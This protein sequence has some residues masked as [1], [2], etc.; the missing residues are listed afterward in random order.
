MGNYMLRYTGV[1]YSWDER[2]QDIPLGGG[3]DCEY[4]TD[5]SKQRF[6]LTQICSNG[7]ETKDGFMRA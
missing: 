6:G 4:T 1:L 2:T 7:I 3:V 5:R